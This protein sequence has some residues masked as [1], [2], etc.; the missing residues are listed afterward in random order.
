[1]LFTFLNNKEERYRHNIVVQN[2]HNKL[3]LYYINFYENS[4]NNI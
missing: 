2:T 4:V 1:M 3:S